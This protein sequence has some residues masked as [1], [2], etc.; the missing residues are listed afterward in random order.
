MKQPKHWY[1]YFTEL[2][3]FL[4]E[5]MLQNPERGHWSLPLTQILMYNVI[6]NAYRRTNKTDVGD[7]VGEYHV[8]KKGLL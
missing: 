1:F 5:K 3:D 2:M 6:N 4:T 8:R 7:R